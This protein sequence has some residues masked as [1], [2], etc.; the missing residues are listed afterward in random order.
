MAG[1]IL[2]EMF[3]LQPLIKQLPGVTTIMPTRL[4]PTSGRYNILIPA[5]KFKE[6]K[7]NIVKKI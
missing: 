7:S 1:P 3:Y 6:V 4:T 2:D 5:G